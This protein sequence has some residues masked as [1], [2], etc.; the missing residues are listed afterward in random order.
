MQCVI[1][2]CKIHGHTIEVRELWTIHPVSYPEI[3]SHCNVTYLEIRSI[4]FKTQPH[5]SHILWYKNEI[6]SK[7]SLMI[8][9]LPNSHMSLRV[10]LTLVAVAYAS[11]TE[12]VLVWT[13]CIHEQNVCSFLNI[14]LH[15]SPLFL[16][17][18]FHR[19]KFVLIKKRFLQMTILW[20]FFIWSTWNLK[21]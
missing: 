6:R 9:T 17:T 18:C 10:Q 19:G 5:N 2:F 8:Q 3:L 13:L 15:W 21:F 20:H 4:Q 16:G 11:S 12:A 7:F 14:T 1:F